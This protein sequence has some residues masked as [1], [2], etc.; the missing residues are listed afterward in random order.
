M[1]ARTAVQT[2][3]NVVGPRCSPTKNKENV[4][5]KEQ[6]NRKNIGGGQGVKQNK[7]RKGKRRWGL[8][9][10]TWRKSR[11]GV[12]WEAIGKERVRT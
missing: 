11:T 10:A 6:Q 5:G 12:F 9:R 7:K 1:K 2:R 3:K 4:G 8:F